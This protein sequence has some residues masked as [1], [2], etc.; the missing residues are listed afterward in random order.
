[1]EKLPHV[2]ILIFSDIHANYE[3]LSSLLENEKYDLSI[4]LGDSVDYGPQPAETLDL[5]MGNTDI[6]IMGNHDRAVAFDEDCHCSLEMHDLSEYTR[7]EI[8]QKFLS[9]EDL[10]KLKGF[11]EF[12]TRDIDGMRLYMT[13]ASPNN[14]LYGYLFSTEA[15][16]VCRDRNLKEFNYILVGHTHFMMIYRNRILNPGSSGQ[17][18][19][20]N[21][22]PT[23]ALFDTDSNII[24]FKRFKYDRE[25]TRR[26]LTEVV[27]DP[28]YLQRLLPFY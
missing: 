2:R 10:A 3:A 16:M 21:P 12:E 25:K 18:R 13:H 22:M 1:M 19:D 7:K 4:F 20:G 15:E 11:S 26:K 24:S 9:R 23:Y 28:T 8:S 5:L 17:P 6:R 27:K 14:H